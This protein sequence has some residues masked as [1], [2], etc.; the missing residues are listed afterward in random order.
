MKGEEKGEQIVTEVLKKK[1]E[2]KESEDI[3]A[4]KPIELLKRK[5]VESKERKLK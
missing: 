1:R 2:R 4:R 5:D 3:G